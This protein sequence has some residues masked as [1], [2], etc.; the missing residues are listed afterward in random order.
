MR[1]PKTTV[2][3]TT[4]EAR[5]G[6]A[7]S[8]TATSAMRPTRERT[9]SVSPVM[10]GD[11]STSATTTMPKRASTLVG[12]A[13]SRESQCDARVAAADAVEEEADEAHEH[14]D[15]E[16][17]ERRDD[18]ER[19]R[20]TDARREPVERLHHHAGEALGV[21]AR[22]LEER[23]REDEP[24]VRDGDLDEAMAEREPDRQRAA[25]GAGADE[26]DLAEAERGHLLGV[27]ADPSAKLGGALGDAVQEEEREQRGE[28]EQREREDGRCDR[29]SLSL[30]RDGLAEPRGDLRRE[31]VEARFAGGLDVLLTERDDGRLADV[32]DGGA[33]RLLEARLA[34]VLALGE[35]AFER[36]VRG[37]RAILRGVTRAR[38]AQGDDDLLVDADLAG[39]RAT[40]GG[41]PGADGAVD[42]ADGG[43]RRRRARARGPGR[44][45]PMRRTRRGRATAGAD[46]D[47]DGARAPP[48][49][50]SC[51]N[52]SGARAIPR[53]IASTAISAANARRRACAARE[54]W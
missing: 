36:V 54:T 38:G 14:A 5:S 27:V 8:A 28:D 45:A 51:A 52:A 50:C 3:P 46:D 41:R 53:R 25:R 48:P 13:R 33:L 47:A 7:A 4:T 20:A 18:H 9:P 24:A 29:A 2:M 16:D 39:E 40:R 26:L 23:E 6:V 49:S 43:R 10:S 34:H 22:R 21:A 37:L 19:E 1:R 15:R 32:D 12:R 35:E 31:H 30:G 44:S 11:A 17:R 42:G